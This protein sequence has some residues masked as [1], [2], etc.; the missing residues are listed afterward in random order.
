MGVLEEAEASGAGLQQ[1]VATRAQERRVN[2][3]QWEV[4]LDARVR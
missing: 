2:E 4:G 3:R 1:V